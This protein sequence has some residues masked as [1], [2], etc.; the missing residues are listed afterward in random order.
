MRPRRASARRRPR[1]A[2]VGAAAVEFALVSLLLFTLVFGIIQY[3]FYFW[4]AQVGASAARDA[5][6]YSA[7]GTQSCT[8]L[9]STVASQL[10]GA[11][12]GSV[13]T[14]RHYYRADGTEVPSGTTGG[15]VTVSV[16]FSSMTLGWVPLP[17]GGQVV[18]DAQARVETATSSSVTCS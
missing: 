7:V 14:T 18:A 15:S 6:R 13:T 1:S 8:A 9:R 3:G 4:A 2:D 12:V 11:A 5:A 17:G 16:R 10:G